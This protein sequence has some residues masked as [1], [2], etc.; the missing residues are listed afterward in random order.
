MDENWYPGDFRKVADPTVYVF[1]EPDQYG[2]KDANG[3]ILAMRRANTSSL[4]PSFTYDIYVD[5][6]RRK[7]VILHVH[8]HVDIPFLIEADVVV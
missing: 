4:K 2:V 1:I 6:K 7:I 3:N 5:P 8:Q